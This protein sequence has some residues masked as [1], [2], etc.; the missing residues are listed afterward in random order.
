VEEPLLKRRD[1]GRR[2]DLPLTADINVTSLVDVAFTLL[3]IFIITAPVLQGGIEIA[4]PRA[5]VDPVTAE[6]NPFFVSVPTSGDVYI[7]ESPVS[8]EE[9]RTAFPQLMG[10]RSVQRVYIRADSMATWGRVLQ[11]TGVVKET[12]QEAGFTF[13]FVG[14]HWD[15]N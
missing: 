13:V 1:L 12:A 14:E 9:F 3:V 15:S 4:V 10:G 6:D 11:V 7:E 2:D 5:A 8:I